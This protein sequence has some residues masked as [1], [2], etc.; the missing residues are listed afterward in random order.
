M[1]FPSLRAVTWQNLA[2]EGPEAQLP[3]EE[4]Q[5]QLPF[6]LQVVGHFMRAQ[7]LVSWHPPDPSNAGFPQDPTHT[8]GHPFAINV[9]H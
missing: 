2:V 6:L 1:S 8:T 4:S 3:E 9:L 5:W 7:L